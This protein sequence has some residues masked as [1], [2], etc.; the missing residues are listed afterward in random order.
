MRSGSISGSGNALPKEMTKAE[1]LLDLTSTDSKDSD[2]PSEK[3]LSNRKAGSDG[4]KKTDD[5]NADKDGGRRHHEAAHRYG[6]G[7]EVN[8]L[9]QDNADGNHE[10]TRY[11]DNDSPGD[12]PP[13]TTKSGR[14]RLIEA[15]EER[16]K[17]IQ[18]E[19]NNIRS[20]IDAADGYKKVWGQVNFSN[21]MTSIDVKDAKGG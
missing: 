5:L 10:G 6:S 13:A 4:V 16:N 1:D 19:L 2:Y 20:S 14:E 12:Q 21:G 11:E 9:D 18:G 17:P 8:A 7:E 15:L 3:D